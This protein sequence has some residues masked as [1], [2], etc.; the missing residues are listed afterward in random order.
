MSDK[1]GKEISLTLKVDAAFRQAVRKVIQQAKQT[2]TPVV[3]WEENRIKEIS[4]DQLEATI[5]FIH[6]EDVRL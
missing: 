3:I 4:S 1:K 6:P 5:S 2:N